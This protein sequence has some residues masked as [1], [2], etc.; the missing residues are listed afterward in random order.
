MFHLMFTVYD[1][2]AKAYT[3]PFNANS[4]NEAIRFFAQTC[5]QPDSMFFQHPNDFCLYYLGT[6]D[7][8]TGL[9]NTISPESC[10][11][12]ATFK[13]PVNGEIEVHNQPDTV[14]EFTGTSKP[15]P[16]KQEAI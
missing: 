1:S 15:Y 3:A 13:V 6:F 11:L 16:Q 8:T 2:T 4:K 9:Y 10:G 5:N 7:N 12:A 14:T